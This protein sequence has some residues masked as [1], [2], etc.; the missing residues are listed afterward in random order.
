MRHLRCQKDFDPSDQSPL[1]Q[2]TVA[3]C[4]PACA[5]NGAWLLYL[6]LYLPSV[7]EG[8]MGVQRDVGGIRVSPLILLGPA[9]R[10]ACWNQRKNPIGVYQNRNCRL[11]R[12]GNSHSRASAPCDSRRSACLFRPLGAA[13]SGPSPILAYWRFAHGIRWAAAQTCLGISS[14]NPRQGT[15]PLDPIHA[16]RL[17]KP[18]VNF[19]SLSLLQQNDSHP[20]PG[21]ESFYT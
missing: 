12:P 10:A 20:F 8:V 13:D 15:S 2:S 21:G 7:S 1:R 3:T 14:P 4:S 5:G 17:S 11:R 6:F 19:M 9:Q 18:L 16:S